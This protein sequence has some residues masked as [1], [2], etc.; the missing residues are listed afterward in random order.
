[1]FAA[2]HIACS[3]GNQ[4][5][6]QVLLDKGNAGVD[7]L[8]I[9]GWS[10]LFYAVMLDHPHCANMLLEHMANPNIQDHNGRR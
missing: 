3:R 10:P 6:A 8:D 2:L 9:N 1:M 7:S 4:D 5:C